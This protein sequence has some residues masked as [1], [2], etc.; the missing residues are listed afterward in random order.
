MALAKFRCASN[1]KYFISSKKVYIQ[2]YIFIRYKL[3]LDE[4]NSIIILDFRIGSS[5]FFV[6]L[7][8][9]LR[10]TNLWGYQTCGNQIKQLKKLEIFLDDGKQNK[11]YS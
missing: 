4:S 6:L 10:N 2:I 3:S 5:D 8:N 9:T 7:V 11:I 1:C